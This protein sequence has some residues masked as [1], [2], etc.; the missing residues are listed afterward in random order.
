M[1]QKQ[2]TLYAADSLVSPSAQPL[3]DVTTPSTWWPEFLR[4]IGDVRPRW[5]IAENVPGIGDDGVDR[6]S[7]DL[8]RQGFAVW[9]VEMDTSPP[10]RSRGRQRIFWLAYSHS[11]GQSRRAQH[12][13]MAR[14]RP[15]SPYR[16]SDDSA[17]VGMDDG[18]PGRMDR[19]KQLGNAVTPYATEIIGRAIMRADR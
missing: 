12:G 19:L 2:L 6:V 18:L 9:P 3:E 13:Q 11:N 10:G 5:V 4:I 16:W 14:I 15:V 1:S 7:R 17:P 8:E